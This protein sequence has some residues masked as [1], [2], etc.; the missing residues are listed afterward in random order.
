MRI[1][2]KDGTI[3]GGNIKLNKVI[4]V[5]MLNSLTDTFTKSTTRYSN[6][7]T[8]VASFGACSTCKLILGI[9]LLIIYIW[10]SGRMVLIEESIGGALN[11]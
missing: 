2:N 1:K 4:K 7:A 6:Y 9:E 8:N 11:L 3:S 5:L 10:F